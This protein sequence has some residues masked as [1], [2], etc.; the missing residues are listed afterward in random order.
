[1]SPVKKKP[2]F[3]DFFGDSDD[4][5]S[6]KST[7]R[8]AGIGAFKFNGLNGS[9]NG[10]AKWKAVDSPKPSP[11][12]PKPFIKTEF[13]GDSHAENAT[14]Q[15]PQPVPMPQPIT[16][17]QPATTSI[18]IEEFPEPKKPLE[19]LENGHY[20]K[21]APPVKLYCPDTS[22]LAS[23]NYV[24]PE[25]LSDGMDISDSDEYD[26]ND[27][28]FINSTITWAK[29]EADV[30]PE[31]DKLE[32]SSIPVPCPP[33]PTRRKS[34]FSSTPNDYSEPFK[35]E[36][37]LQIPESN[38]LSIQPK[39]TAEEEIKKE[40]IE[41]E[42][43]MPEFTVIDEPHYR[44]NKDFVRAEKSMRN[45]D[46]E[47]RLPDDPAAVCCGDECIN[48]ATL[49]E[50]SNRCKTGD[51]C[52]NR[53][54]QRGN[55]A[56]VEV[57]WTKGKGHGLRATSK[58]KAGTF[59]M[60]YLGE[61]VSAKEFKKR[62]HEY[63][64]LGTKHHYFM[65]LSQ[66]A[67]I[68]AYHEGS[69]SRFINHSC[70][71][72]AETQKWTV[73][74]IV[75]IGFFSTKDIQQNQEITFDYQF[76]H[77]G[78]AQTCLCGAPS[79]R[80]VIG[81][82]ADEAE[83]RRKAGVDENHY[84]KK[85]MKFK[86]L[87]CK[88]DVQELIRYMGRVR[89]NE[90]DARKKALLLIGNAE[91]KLKKFFINTFG[92]ELLLTYAKEDNLEDNELKGDLLW[93]LEE[94][95]ISHRN[96]VEDND[97]IKMMDKWSKDEDEHQERSSALVS[98]WRK[99][100]RL[101][102]LKKIV[103]RKPSE[104]SIPVRETSPKR[105]DNSNSYYRRRSPPRKPA[106]PEI[107]PETRARAKNDHRRRFEERIKIEK[108]ELALRE[109]AR[110]QSSEQVDASTNGDAEEHYDLGSSVGPITPPES[111]DPA[112]M[113][114]DEQRRKIKRLHAH[115]KPSEDDETILDGVACLLDT[116]EDG[117][118]LLRINFEDK[119]EFFRTWANGRK[120]EERE[121]Q[122]LKEKEKRRRKEAEEL[123]MERKVAEAMQNTAA[124]EEAE[125]NKPFSVEMLPLGWKCAQDSEGE[126]YYYHEETQET[127]WEPPEMS[128]KE[129]HER[130]MALRDKVCKHL[131]RALLVYRD[132]KCK[133]GR[134]TSDD[135]LHYVVRKCGFSIAK[136]I[137]KE[138]QT[139]RL[140]EEGIKLSSRYT[141]KFLSKSGRN[142]DKHF[143]PRAA[144]KKQQQQKPSTTSSPV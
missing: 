99:L 128:D 29:T 41:E 124:E 113:T 6:T 122:R 134:I 11:V 129:R 117:S 5:E 138:L 23:I 4:E 46:C 119:E 22:S 37:S 9:T 104:E 24:D 35:V 67:T 20:A 115:I 53:D 2:T 54:F 64:R 81:R 1:V 69:I 112:E 7:P 96:K 79:C 95:D 74:G 110:L 21:S 8:I 102:P 44:C 19:N 111:P 49:V 61:V 72:N 120:F 100:S 73:N 139:F 132:D 105:K 137:V 38:N 82:E 52:T 136:R 62:S 86:K 70:E 78:K 40:E 118:L 131:S 121:K 57:F 89:S 130:V 48:R 108:E 93:L 10:D 91:R 125:K 13:S 92:M 101:I 133:V 56:P 36:P 14:S 27:D 55:N 47:C 50:C 123:A 107:D 42:P 65:E 17:P 106:E 25:I 80:G 68:D 87:H 140:T 15:M 142:F 98:K 116:Q 26:E 103:A 97:W 71:P 75:R 114:A 30:K 43:P 85:I 3:N 135:D 94:L 84:S 28:D 34:R 90:Q 51:R 12:R 39:E 66:Q 60:E 16:T 76:I 18:P 59:I 143:V 88:E 58:V 31:P 63:A 141:R 126:T 109:A 144:T 45:M 127:Q 33:P 83:Y 32:P 77:F